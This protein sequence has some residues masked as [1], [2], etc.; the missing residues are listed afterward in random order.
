MKINIFLDARTSPPE[1]RLTVAHRSQRALL[2]LGL[3]LNADQWDESRQRVKS[4]P[5]RAAVQ[6]FI[7]DRRRIAEDTALALRLDGR[8]PR[9]TAAAVRDIIRA[10]ING[11]STE[12]RPV[13]LIERVQS[14][15]QT[16]PAQRTREI[17]LNTAKII[18]RVMGDIALDD[19]N[20]QWLTKL[21]R[22]LAADGIA[23]NTRAIHFRNIRAVI[24]D[25]I[26]NELTTNYPFRRFSIKKE[27]T[28]HRALGIDDLRRIINV[29]EWHT[30]MFCLS[31]LLIGINA[32]DLYE[33]TAGNI[34]GDRLVYRR[35]K[36]HRLI[37]IRLEPEALSIIERNRG[38]RTLLN[39]ADRYSNA[40]NF[41]IAMSKHMQR[42][43]E[44]ITLYWARHTWATV[45]FSLGIP[46][47]TISRA[48]GHSFSTGAAVTAV[49]VRTDTAD[50]DAAAR[51]VVDYVFE[52]K[53]RLSSQT[54]GATTNS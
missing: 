33:L 18:A 10:A 52:E 11:E 7:D 12:H 13:T 45:A 31:F 22:R 36:T 3:H 49:Y 30:D 51:R 32:A 53:T 26:D 16:R 2:S 28:A 24:N 19:L 48:L 23:V 20:K 54:S 50:I 39:I 5:Q 6:R 40:H 27:E 14:F 44:G 21:D 29:G 15:A 37:S 42:H 43:H 1:L 35:Q 17:Y 4:H 9:L 46:M 34:D 38:K 41:T 47:D 25:A 8:L